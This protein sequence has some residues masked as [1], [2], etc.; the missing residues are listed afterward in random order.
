MLQNKNKQKNIHSTNMISALSYGIL[1]SV[2]I[3]VILSFGTA[4]GIEKEILNE[5]YISKVI[6][7]IHIISVFCGSLL[8]II[9]LKCKKIILAA[10]V[11]SCYIV[12]LLITGALFFKESI[13][14]AAKMILP[15][16]LGFAIAYGFHLCMSSKKKHA[17]KRFR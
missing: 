12:V 11:M 16:I 8:S 5:K 17:I 13:T 1:I 2:M 3:C 7:S 15:A 4:L 9:Q 10:L 6:F 14:S